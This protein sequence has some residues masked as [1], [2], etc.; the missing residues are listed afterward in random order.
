MSKALIPLPS[1]FRWRELWDFRDMNGGLVPSSVSSGHKLTATG[2]TKVTTAD[3][4]HFLAGVATSNIEFADPYD[5]V[6]DWWVSFRSKLGQ[7]FSSAESTDMYLLGKYDDG[8]NYLVIYLRASDGA[9]VFDH[10]EGGGQEIVVS[11]ETSWAAGQWYHVLC[12][13]STTNGKRLIID[14]GTP[15]AEAGDQTAISLTASITI[16]ARD[17]GTSTEG[18]SATIADVVMGNDALT[19]TEETDLSNGVKPVDAV[20]SFSLDEGR[21]TVANDK[22]TGADNGTLDS[23]CTWG[24][25][26]PQQVCAG[27]DGINDRLL[28]DSGVDISGPLTAVWVGKE[29]D[30]YEGNNGPYKFYIAVDGD[31]NISLIHQ[32][33]INGHRFRCE[34]GGVAVFASYSTLNVIDEYVIFIGTLTL[35]GVVEL[36]RNGVSVAT[37]AGAGQISPAAATFSLSLPAANQDISKPILA[38]LIDGV[39]SAQQVLNLTR[40]INQKK[41]L[42]LTI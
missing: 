40:Y 25:G 35:A 14:A 28:S 39:L 26:G 37:S 2:A 1:G 16:G 41:R 13:I 33:G 17:N 10:T 18:V 5:A 19:G 7:A 22:G 24:F 8:T 30:T 12:S 15:V 31:D 23:S 21:G 11:A 42:G 29:K 9:L 6:N 34:G 27:M 3:G 36:F 4:V 32:A 38:G 20:N